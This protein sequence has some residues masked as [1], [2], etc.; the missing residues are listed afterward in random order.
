MGIAAIDT[1]A[2]PIMGADD[3]GSMLEARPRAIIN[4]GNGDTAYCH[5]ADYHSNDAAIPVGVSYGVKL[6]EMVLKP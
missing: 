5:S 3:F 1:D 6:V 2:R 4:L